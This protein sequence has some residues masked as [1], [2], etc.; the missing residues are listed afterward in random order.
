M[1]LIQFFLSDFPGGEG[2]SQCVGRGSVK[3]VKSFE[4]RRALGFEKFETSPLA[5]R[6]H[7]DFLNGINCILEV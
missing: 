6:G 7:K 3:D 1:T 5:A 4:G 2:E